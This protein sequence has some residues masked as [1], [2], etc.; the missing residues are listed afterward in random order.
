MNLSRVM[1]GRLATRTFLHTDWTTV[2]GASTVASVIQGDEGW[3]DLAGFVDATFW[4]D[5]S[6]VTPPPGGTL[7]LQLETSPTGDESTFQVVAGP[8]VC[9]ASTT[10]IVLKTASAGAFPLCRFNRW[11]VVSTTNTSWDVTFRIRVT[12]NRQMYFAPTQLSNCIVWLRADIGTSFASGGLVSG[13]ADLSGNGYNASQATPGNQPNFSSTA[14][15]SATN[16]VLAG[17]PAIQGDGVARFMA[18][19]PIPVTGSA[20]YIAV[21]QPTG[22]P[23][24]GY[25]RL[26]E[27]AFNSAYYLGTDVNGTEYK[28]IV[29][30][31]ISPY[32]TAVGSSVMT[33]TNTIVT[34]AYSAPAGTLYVNGSSIAS[35]STNFTTPTAANLALHIMDDVGATIF[36]KGYVAEVIVYNRTLTAAEFQQ[37]HRYLGAR[38]AITVP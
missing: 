16:P 21:V 31:S 19:S 7:L 6:E 3:L 9:T 1:G 34:G 20:T 25:T 2:R 14:M 13:W 11:R 15:G 5:F 33:N 37:V 27:T 17:M 8:I 18:T 26:I 30:Y 32:G 35:D 10:P 29:D 24:S 4:V 22:S 38:Y 23:Q 36:W 12:A 28:L